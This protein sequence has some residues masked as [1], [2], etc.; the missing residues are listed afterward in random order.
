MG[1]N[2]DD[3][4]H[5][6]VFKFRGCNLTNQTWSSGRL[7]RPDNP[8]ASRNALFQWV[9]ARI[10]DHNSWIVPLPVAKN[11]WFLSWYHMFNVEK[12]TSIYHAWPHASPIFLCPNMMWPYKLW[13]VFTGQVMTIRWN[14]LEFLPVG[15][16]RFPQWVLV[17]HNTSWLILDT[18]QKIVNS[19]NVYHNIH[20]HIIYM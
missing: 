14:L 6:S 18:L 9:W 12:K 20:L 5:F 13:C 8:L 16:C 10:E 2:R 15:W 3:V 7:W 4:H 17:L 19:F 11:M 1:K